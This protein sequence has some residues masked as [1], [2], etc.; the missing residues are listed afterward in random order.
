VGLNPILDDMGIQGEYPSHPELLDWLAVEFQKSGWDFKHMVRLIA[1]SD[2]YQRSSTPD[3]VAEA[4]DPRNRWLAHQNARRLDAEIIRDNALAISGLLNRDMGGPPVF[5][6]QP[7][8][9]YEHLQF[10]D[11]NW[12]D[13]TDDRQYRRG[14]YTHWQ[15]TFLHPMLANFD[16]PAR[17]E[18]TGM[19]LEAN[20]PLQALTLLNDTTFVEAARVLAADVVANGSS[21]E[22]R[23]NH[24]Y[25][26]TLARMPER[27][28]E[29][30]LLK[31]LNS[32]RDQF[33]SDPESARR[34][35]SLGNAP[36]VELD[37]PTD[38]AAWVMVS[39]AVLNLH[40][41]ITR[42]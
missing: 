17:E 33:R 32:Q 41:T 1:L 21:D 36:V 25:R 19:R 14:V 30:S 26:R 6:Y 20:T 37:D 16:A 9:Y 15:R 42:Y 39:R 10:P 24:L 7:G 34:L 22:D 38:L 13:A 2:T 11:R 4:S 27:A 3:S 28:E 23:L 5:P 18:C 40:E 35:L 31:L 29:A 12:R 8:G